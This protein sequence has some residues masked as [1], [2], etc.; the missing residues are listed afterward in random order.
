MEMLQD[1]PKAPQAWWWLFPAIGAVGSFIGGIAGSFFSKRGEIAAIQSQIS[2]V[3]EQNERLV[4]SSESI[5]TEL[6]DKS[7]SKQR[8]W[9]N[10][11]DAAVDILRMYGKL[12]E[13]LAWLAQIRSESP[14]AKGQ[15]DQKWIKEIEVRY[16]SMQETRLSP[17]M[18]D[19]WQLAELSRLVFSKD[20]YDRMVALK[21]TIND[22]LTEIAT[23]GKKQD[24]SFEQF[25]IKKTAL[26]EAIRQELEM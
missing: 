5:K 20:I 17:V 16:N 22:L 26:A 21:N 15:N 9:D 2:T 12:S 14:I 4:R 3:V 13:I 25:E 8:H 23:M 6:S 11:R 7:F 24:R 18:T 10:K 19:F 1:L